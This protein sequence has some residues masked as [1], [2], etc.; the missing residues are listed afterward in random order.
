MVV[1]EHRYD[2]AVSDTDTEAF[3][4]KSRNSRYQKSWSIISQMFETKKKTWD[5]H[6]HCLIQIMVWYLWR[7]YFHRVQL[8]VRS[9]LFNPIIT[10]SARPP[11]VLTS[12]DRS[13]Q[14]VS[15][16]PVWYARFLHGVDVHLDHDRPIQQDVHVHDLDEGVCKSYWLAWSD[17]DQHER[18]FEGRSEVAQLAVCVA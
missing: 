17:L 10:K 18:H 3:F 4:V 1:N 12:Q 14:E 5:K 6:F 13:P 16:H 9:I 11:A 7:S 8:D 2:K 15:Y